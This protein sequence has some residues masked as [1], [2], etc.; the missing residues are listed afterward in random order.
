L[1]GAPIPGHLVVNGTTVNT[2][3]HLA[4]SRQAAG[5]ATPNLLSVLQKWTLP[6]LAGCALVLADCMPND[7]RE[8][9]ASNTSDKQQTTK[10]GDRGT[11]TLA[12]LPNSTN[13]FASFSKATMKALPKKYSQGNAMKLIDVDMI[14]QPFLD[15]AL[16][17]VKNLDPALLTEAGVNM[18]NLLK[19]N[20]STANLDGTP[21]ADLMTLADFT[22]IG[23]GS[24]ALLAEMLGISASQD[25]ISVDI[26]KEVIGD[27]LLRRHPH[28]QPDGKVS[29]YLSDALSDMATLVR[30]AQADINGDGVDDNTG[31]TIEM[32][33]EDGNP[34]V[35]CLDQNGDLAKTV[36]SDNSEVDVNLETCRKNFA[37]GL[38]PNVISDG[39]HDTPISYSSESGKCE[40]RYWAAL[41]CRDVRLDD[42]NA[43]SDQ[44]LDDY[45]N[46]LY[47]DP[48]AQVPLSSPSRDADVAIVED[49]CDLEAQDSDPN[50]V[51]VRNDGYNKSTNKRYMKMG[52]FDRDEDCLP[53]R[54]AGVLAGTFV[55]VDE[56]ADGVDDVSNEPISFSGQIDLD[57]NGFNDFPLL[58]SNECSAS[59]FILGFCRQVDPND[60]DY[61]A[62]CAPI[63]KEDGTTATQEQ[64]D[65]VGSQYCTDNPDNINCSGGQPGGVLGDEG[66]SYYLPMGTRDVEPLEH[67]DCYPDSY[68]ALLRGMPESSIMGDDFKMS[69]PARVNA[70]AQQ[71]FD[72]S[73]RTKANKDSLNAEGIDLYVTTDEDPN[74]VGLQIF[75]LKDNTTISINFAMQEYVNYQYKDDTNPA[76]TKENES[77]D[78]DDDRCLG[79]D[80]FIG[81]EY[82]H[83]RYQNSGLACDA[84]ISQNNNCLADRYQTD[85]GDHDAAAAGGTFGLHM[86]GIDTVRG[87]ASVIG[88]T[89]DEDGVWRWNNAVAEADNPGW[90]D[91]SGGKVNYRYMGKNRIWREIDPFNLEYIILDSAYRSFGDMVYYGLGH[92]F[93]KLDPSFNLPSSS[94]YSDT[95]SASEDFSVIGGGNFCHPLDYNRDI[96]NSFQE[97]SKGQTTGSICFDAPAMPVGM[98]PD[99]NS[100]DKLLWLDYDYRNFSAG[101]GDFSG[102]YTCTGSYDVDT[103][104]ECIDQWY[105]TRGLHKM[106]LSGSNPAAEVWVG[107]SNFGKFGPASNG[108]KANY[109]NHDPVYDGGDWVRVKRDYLLSDPDLNFYMHDLVSMVAQIRMHDTATRKTAEY[110]CTVTED[111]SV[112]AKCDMPDAPPDPEDP[113]GANI[114]RWVAFYGFTHDGTFTTSPGTSVGIVRGISQLQIDTL[115]VDRNDGSGYVELEE[116]VDYKVATGLDANRALRIEF[117]TADPDPQDDIDKTN[118]CDGSRVEARLREDDKIRISYS[119]VDRLNE[120]DASVTFELNDINLGLSK[121]EIQKSV[122][123]TISSPDGKGALLDIA[124]GLFTNASGEPDLYMDR[125]Y[126]GGGEYDYYIRYFY[127]DGN[128]DNPVVAQNIAAYEGVKLGFYEDQ[129]LTT[130][131]NDVVGECTIDHACMAIKVERNADGSTM[132]K[133]VYFQ[134]NTSGSEGKEPWTYRLRIM[135]QPAGNE[136]KFEWERVQ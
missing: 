89:E 105:E 119:Y 32:D 43:G 19:M 125:V 70:T 86:D 75:G 22:G 104:N 21:M 73:T 106:Y 69:M 33:G 17:Q 110:T 121:E 65:A 46:V 54:Y 96:F 37:D 116:D 52:G 45:C 49:W 118:W 128:P 97:I 114:S 7:P 31:L 129:A 59:D 34:Q 85:Y 10:V 20:P 63:V 25:F 16:F 79:R 6:L 126:A 66:I 81:L 76:C 56:N 123:E 113:G 135:E 40:A 72:F 83:R 62:I 111:G 124:D 131:I 50:C 98:L 27:N 57:A 88:L 3:V 112:D 100:L 90:H 109:A 108:N 11:V 78:L 71:G 136:V 23:G 12:Y 93:R 132:Q 74:G 44:D 47:R 39:Y 103:D 94:A 5:S 28:V 91:T 1:A 117:C 51:D 99:G 13:I 130:P 58:H 95:W 60:V 14:N 87:G 82:D 24:A 102:T 61:G 2:T 35:D 134:D 115:E 30:L 92:P 80:S 55:Q 42:T 127:P 26:L 67:P 9:K 101:F 120:G 133:E 64:Y 18:Q 4:I 107:V 68:Q 29:I 41:I 84:E 122:L 36:L 53:D 8:S 77:D 48:T 15:N 38:S